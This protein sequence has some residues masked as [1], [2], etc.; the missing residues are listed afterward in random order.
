MLASRCSTQ[1]LGA[2]VLGLVIL[3]NTCISQTESAVISGRVTDASGAVVIGAEVRLQSAEHNTTAT[4]NTNAAG[5]YNFATIQPGVYNLTVRKEG[6]RQVDFVGLVA[7]VQAHID[8]NFQ[9]Q[10]GAVSESITVKA[11]GAPLVNTQDAAVSTVVDRQFVENMPLNGRSFQSLIELT[12]GATITP[13]DFQEPGQF[14]FNGQRPSA[15]YFMVDGVSAN[16]AVNSQP[17]PN[18]NSAGT[19]P[20]FTVSGGTNGLVSVDAMQEFR[21]QTSTYAPE[22]G[23]T[24]GGQVSIVTRSGTNRFHGTAFD[25]L[26]NDVLDANDWFSNHAGLAKSEE[27]QNDF[28][29]VLGGPIWKDH[30]FFFL[31]YEGLRL[32]LPEVV[33]T[34]V[35]GAAARAGAPASIQPFLNTYPQ[36]TGSDDASGSAPFVAGFSDASTLD[37][38]AIRIDHS[39]NDRLRLF[40]RYDRAVSDFGDRGTTNALNT[41]DLVKNELQTATVGATWMIKSRL[42]NDVRFNY[43]NNQGSSRLVAD[44]FGGASSPPPDTALFPTGFTSGDSRYAFQIISLGIHGTWQAGRT[45]ANVQRQVN[46][47]DSLSWQEGKHA[48]KFGVDWRR[49]FPEQKPL[50]YSMQVVFFD[51]PSAVALNPVE[52]IVLHEL[53]S[54][55]SY[56]NLGLFAQDTWRVRPRLSLTYGVRWDVDFAPK[57]VDGPDLIALTQ[58]DNISTT[59]VASAGTP[60]YRTTYG[61]FAPRV[62]IAYEVSQKQNW[63]AVLRGGFGVFYDLASSQVGQQATIA[64]PYAGFALTF[65]PGFPIPPEVAAPPPITADFLSQVQFA[66]DPHLQLPYSL[67][68]NAAVEQALGTNQVFTAT[69][70]GQV[71]RRLLQSE[72]LFPFPNPDFFGLALTKNTSTS[73]YHALQLQLQRRMSRGLQAMVS[74]TFSHSIDTASA[75]QAISTTS[76][77]SIFVPNTNNRS[78]SDFDIRQTLAA[79][80]SYD[81]PG[82][83]VNAFVNAMARDWSIDSVFQARTAPPVDIQD[84]DFFSISNNIAFVRPDL[85]TGV[86][87]FLA[88]PSV[89]GGKQINP[90]AFAPPA[91]SQ[92]SLGRNALR[93]FAAYQWDFAIRREFKLR[94]SVHL[95]FRTEFFNILNHPNFA[96]PLNQWSSDPLVLDPNFG[97]SQQMLARQLGGT[98]NS[99]FLPLYQLGGPRSIQVALRL[100]F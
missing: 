77:G 30:T 63:N 93:G 27:R 48:L 7:N 15:N 74:Y 42:V 65:F 97:T 5:I 86:P 94:E 66:S 58:V 28:G 31:S 57:A 55:I 35:P 16:V 82:P 70:V 25:Y 4:T 96:Q 67:Q 9:L 60:V 75:N 32:R 83:H 81:I 54:T 59:A 18:Q 10:V 47:V 36:P 90:G 69:Y 45:A 88:N 79:A 26:R 62:G 43:S 41:T 72:I 19:T 24:P 61:N 13:G 29:G 1:I 92:G 78:S 33:S 17:S 80:V 39:V 21:I 14:S 8:Q 20:G 51:V 71:G 98:F 89:A 38:L 68:W 37:A 99:G 95:Q 73:D 11:E 3:P 40:A 49:L 76:S 46:L 12:P 100:Q 84:I 56:S 22:F 44:T 53:P 2:L 64:Y 6:F 23:R 85:V 87:I 52:A 34:F 91:G 50:Q